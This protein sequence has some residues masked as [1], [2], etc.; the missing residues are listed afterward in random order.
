MTLIGS[1]LDRYVYGYHYAP[2][3]AV[4]FSKDLRLLPKDTK[5]LV[6]SDKEQPFYDA[7]AEHRDDLT[8][9]D[10]PASNLESFTA[11]RAARDKVPTGYTVERIIT[12]T[13]SNDADR[14]YIYKKVQ[15]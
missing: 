7:V 15:Q 9:L 14:L 11:T 10:K 6:V 8:V 4:N 1:G 12:T 3:T 2:S 5:N 13:Y